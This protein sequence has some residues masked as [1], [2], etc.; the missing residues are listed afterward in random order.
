MSWMHGPLLAFDLET[1][2]VDVRRSFPISFALVPYDFEQPGKGRYGLINP[3]IPMPPDALA[4]HHITDEM[5]QQR[6][7]PLN[8]SILGIA[9]ALTDASREGRPL[10]GMNVRFDLSII[11]QRL[12]HIDG[13]L[14]EAF[15]LREGHGW[16]GLVIDALELDRKVDKWRKGKRNLAT[17]CEVYG[18]D[19]G[20]SHNAGADARAA[21]EVVLAIARKHP[22]LSKLSAEELHIQQFAWH[23]EWAVDYGQYRLDHNQPPLAE[24]EA[25]WPILGDKRVLILER[26]DTS[27]PQEPRC[28]RERYCMLG[29]NHEGECD[30]KF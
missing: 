1:T 13:E 16:N 12:R 24:D 25:D 30:S 3:G 17:L 22:W 14:G 9:D 5:V 23:H 21:A 4:I 10:V 8:R 7:G 29:L 20:D 19:P 11:D 6:G 27:P 15:G 28:T 2:G 18:V 26:P